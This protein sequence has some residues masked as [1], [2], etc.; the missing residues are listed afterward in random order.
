MFRT[1]HFDPRIL[2]LKVGVI[3]LCTCVRMCI[4]LLPNDD[5]DLAFVP[6]GCTL[7][8]STVAAVQ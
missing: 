2:L 4:K 7:Q 5:V 1:C 6:F 8:Q 3:V